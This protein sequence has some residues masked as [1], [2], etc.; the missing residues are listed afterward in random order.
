VNRILRVGSGLV[1]GGSA[2][3]RSPWTALT[4]G[5]ACIAAAACGGDGGTGPNPPPPP[6]PP[7]PGTVEPAIALDLAPGEGVVLR[8]PDE[9][10][11][12]QL[13]GG[14]Q[15]RE[16]QVIVQSASEVFGA[17]TQMRLQLTATGASASVVDAGP[18]PR[19]TPV[20]SRLPHL[21]ERRMSWYRQEARLRAA[22]REELRRVNARPIRAGE[23][24]VG[25][26]LSVASAPPNIGDMIQFNLAVTPSLA[27]DCDNP[28]SIDAEITFV[29]QHFAIAEDVQNAGNFSPAEYADLGQ[30]FD[31][32]VYPL[33][34]S[35]FGDPADID[36]NDVVIALITAE[37]NKLTP[38]GSGTLIA[39]F[40]FGGDL[41]DTSVCAASNQGELLYIVAPD[42]GGQ[43]SDPIDA[44]E[45]LS[46]ARTTV[47]H[48][49]LHLLNT[50]QRV[51]IG[52]GTFADQEDAWLDEGLA[53]LAEELVGLAEGGSATR[54]NLDL[55]AL[56]TTQVSQDAFNDFHL[57]NMLRV[58]RFM[59]DPEGTPALGNSQG[60]DP[61]DEATLLMRGFGY[62]MSRWLGDQFGPSGSGQL[63]GSNEAAFFRELSSGGPS[64]LTGTAN[65][66]R[67]VQVV[68][69]QATPW[70]D[71][72]ASF[73]G[74]LVLDDTGLSGLEEEFQSKTWDY[75]GLF[76]QLSQA[77]FCCDENGNTVPPPAVFQNEYPLM[78]ADFSLGATT[79]TSS[80]FTVN[81]S[82]GAFFHI[83][84]GSTTPDA[85]LEVTTNSGADL[86]PGVVAQ[87]TVVRIR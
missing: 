25:P 68:G 44:E 36:G 31:D 57:I 10:R 47:G 40:F 78:P 62:M 37:V 32:T 42:P 79:N 9:V 39:G 24:P 27:V 13:D 41:T 28:T 33:E 22:M 72:L 4:M 55:D 85:V 11:A 30:L 65:V 73:L 67:A 45:A 82:T 51:T 35:Y 60:N 26:R 80:S 58:A 74:M 61:S 19:P 54:A 6:P 53:H 64:R 66:E 20:F 49:F 70:E 84:G 1:D 18:G 5:L 71:L 87:V 21:A 12:F 56:V 69:G 76:L 34:T 29:G 15:T 8:A 50:Q 38:A 48:E 83:T 77:N 75:R 81:A 7:P 52:G 17:E 46:L 86:G 16:Y 23:G 2:G 43:F 14:P 63:P 3:R 59:L